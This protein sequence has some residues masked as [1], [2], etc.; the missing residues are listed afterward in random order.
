MFNLQTILYLDTSNTKNFLKKN[1]GCGGGNYLKIR[2]PFVNETNASTRSKSIDTNIVETKNVQHSYL[3]SDF[4]KNLSRGD[5]IFEKT[6]DEINL[7]NIDPNKWIQKIFG[8][9]H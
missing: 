7:E 2:P 3:T 8:D 5:N 9:I 6:H 4:K 1:N